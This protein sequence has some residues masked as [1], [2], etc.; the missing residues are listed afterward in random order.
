[1][2]EP[3]NTQP[4]SEPAKGGSESLLAI[5][6]LASGVIS[7]CGVVVPFVGVPFALLA[8]VLGYF[9]RRSVERKNLATIGMVLGGVGIL[10]SCV[11]VSVIA[12]MRLLGPKIGN[13]FSTITSSLP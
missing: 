1:M 3:L 12:I 2:N 6:S 10:L 11:P 13:T 4:V 8:L 9:G 7:L 5:L